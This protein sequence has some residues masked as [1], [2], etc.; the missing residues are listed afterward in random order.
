[1]GG[2]RCNLKTIVK[3]QGVTTKSDG[4]WKFLSR[5]AWSY[6]DP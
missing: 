6:K 3:A 1:M 2:T 5:V 4:M